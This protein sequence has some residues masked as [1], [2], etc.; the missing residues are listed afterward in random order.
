MRNA[1]ILLAAAAAC[2]G[3]QVRSLDVAVPDASVPDA[4]V[5][6]P[7]AGHPD[8]GPPDAGPPDAGP[9]DAG[10]PHKAELIEVHDSA[11]WKIY[12]GADGLPGTVM[13]ASADEAGRLWV[14]GGGSG[15]FALIDGR[16][17]QF[18][19][20]YE[21]ISIA[22][23]PQD[24]AFVGYNG[25]GDCE[26]EWDRFPN[27]VGADP[28]IYKSG[29]ADKLILQG[30]SV[31][32]EHYDI[33]SG[34]GLV[35]AEPSGREKLCTVYR[36]LY[37]KNAQLVWFGANHGFATGFVNSTAVYEHVHPAIND[38]NGSFMT[39]FYYGLALDTVPH[40]D[41]KSGKTLFD[42]WFGGYIRTTR[43]RYGE[44]LGD[45][46]A[47]ADLTQFYAHKDDA[48]DISNDPQAQA[49]FWN[50]MDIWPDPVGERRE[51]VNKAG[52]HTMWLSS[53]PDKNNPADWNLD[54][55]TGIAVLSD[56]SAWIGS[57][58]NGMRHV[59]H[60]GH[61]IEDAPKILPGKSIGALVRDPSDDSVW[62]GYRDQGM[63]LSRLM[64]NGDVVHYGAPAV[65]GR[66]NSQVWDLQIS[67][68]SPRQVIVAFRS[69]AVGVYTGK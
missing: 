62:I 43:F 6:V 68:G 40:F 51:G 61:F 57:W 53:E 60:D 46:D 23:G 58:S 14:A 67:Q 34:P 48:G 63:G 33:S 3:N 11:G 52:Q 50:R 69:G 32:R 59:D 1:L 2:G 12:T 7:D 15:A 39:G 45:L 21:A 38:K 44:T 37:D 56:G 5:P 22:G 18:S 28:A 13:G 19:T 54:N 25:I 10:P 49:A 66:V 47:A 8:A 55:V 35:A 31:T 65:G 4:S 27:H 29:D 9:P 36:V 30:T 20:P 16:F 41:A 17:H 24:V 26:D 42:V 64:P